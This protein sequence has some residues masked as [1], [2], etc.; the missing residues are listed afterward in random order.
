MAWLAVA[1]FVAGCGSRQP[2]VLAQLPGQFVTTTSRVAADARSCEQ[3]LSESVT[4][5]STGLDSTD[6]RLL[7]WNAQKG[8][9]NNWQDDFAGMSSDRNLVLLQEALPEHLFPGRYSPVP[10]GSFA[11][12][13]AGP[14]GLT[15]VLTLSAAEPLT[16]CH[17][18]NREPWLRTIKA[19]SVTEYALSNTTATLAVINVHAI[20]FS[21]GVEAFSRQLGQ[22]SDV[23]RAHDGPVIV[24]GDFNTWSQNRLETVRTMAQESGLQTLVIPDDGRS[25]FFGRRVDHVFVRGL[26][27]VAAATPA[28]DTS[29]HNPIVAV[30]RV[31]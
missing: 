24:S 7:S 4:T 21:L 2:Y 8:G 9:R 28:V 13:F 23:L 19:T 5:A 27:T 16:Q 29:D 3:L 15:G 22:I 26:Q 17:L 30:F 25:T 12:G 14:S 6:I 11:P 1:I 10:Y 20:N 18:E 31:L